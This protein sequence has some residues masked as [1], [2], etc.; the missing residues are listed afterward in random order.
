METEIDNFTPEQIENFRFFFFLLC[1][2]SRFPRAQAIM[3]Q[4]KETPATESSS[5]SHHKRDI[6]CFTENCLIRHEGENVYRPS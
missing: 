6:E 5:H 2:T 1:A 3:R 4:K